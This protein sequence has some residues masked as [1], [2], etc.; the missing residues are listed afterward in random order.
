MNDEQKQQ[1]VLVVD[2][3]PDAVQMLRTIVEAE[4]CR[5][6]SASDGDECVPMAKEQLP[7][8]I[9]LDVMM[10]RVN[11]FEAFYRLQQ[12]EQTRGIPVVMLTGVS[13]H[14]GIKFS[15]ESMGEF[16]GRGPAGYI[17]KPVQPELLLK[18]IRDLLA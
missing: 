7:D 12:D 16:M 17:E 15:A 6:I 2:D 4:G 14:T 18:T 1:T 13:E 3:E 10:K 11:G 5:V 8:L 9:I